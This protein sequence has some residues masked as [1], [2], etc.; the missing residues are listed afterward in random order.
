MWRPAPG[1]CPG[2]ARLALAVAVLGGGGYLVV[3]LWL[4]GHSVW[5]VM[6]GA[7]TLGVLAWIYPP[8]VPEPE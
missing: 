7:V 1:V 3:P 2:L 6:G 8:P 4:A 5:G